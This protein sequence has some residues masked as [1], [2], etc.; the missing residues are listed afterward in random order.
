MPGCPD[1]EPGK[2]EVPVLH[3]RQRAPR[4]GHLPSWRWELRL[5]LGPPQRAR[6]V[7]LCKQQSLLQEDMWMGQWT[8]C[9]RGLGEQK[10]TPLSFHQPCPQPHSP[11]AAS[12][13][14]NA[15]RHPADSISMNSNGLPILLNG[16]SA[17]TLL[18]SLALPFTSCVTTGQSL[19]SLNLPFLRQITK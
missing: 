3:Q 13:L 10:L 17:A 8:P 18:S 19:T 1:G 14:P 4:S 5:Q 11:P 2:Q 16:Y 12:E 9:P 15:G 7:P 6:N